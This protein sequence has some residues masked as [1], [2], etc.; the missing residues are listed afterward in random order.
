MWGP[1]LALIIV[2]VL[3]GVVALRIIGAGSE[4][5]RSPI[6]PNSQ[7]RDIQT[8]RTALHYAEDINA[9]DVSSLGN[10]RVHVGAIVRLAPTKYREGVLEIQRHFIEG[11]VVSVDLGRLDGASAAR[12]VDFCSGL[13]CGSPG[14]I[15]RVTDSVIILTPVVKLGSKDRL[16]NPLKEVL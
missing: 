8:L 6:L 12:V 5:R 9:F 16:S 15:L 3:S 2:L 14:W 13:L 11:N 1:V 10:P 4:V 7:S